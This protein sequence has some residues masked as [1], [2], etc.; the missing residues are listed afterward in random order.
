[1]VTNPELSEVRTAKF[2][3]LH[4]LPSPS[5][6]ESVVVEDEREEEAD[7]NAVLQ[8]LGGAFAM[9]MFAINDD[10][11]DDD[12]GGGGGGGND[13]GDG[14]AAAARLLHAVST[15]GPAA[16]ALAE[17]E[18]WQRLGAEAAELTASGAPLPVGAQLPRRISG[19]EGAAP[20]RARI[21]GELGDAGYVVLPPLGQ[22]QHGPSSGDGAATAAA[23]A[24]S[25]AATTTKAA[26]RT[27]EMAAAVRVVERHGWPPVFALMLDA[28]WTAIQRAW[29]VAGAV[30]G[31]DCDLEPSIFI[32]SLRRNVDP[33]SSQQKGTGAG[34][35]AA[36]VP[37]TAE[38]GDATTTTT[39]TT[40]TDWSSAYGVDTSDAAE[41]KRCQRVG[42]NFGLPHR[43]FSYDE[44]HFPG[45]EGLPRVCNVWIP[46]TDATVDNGCLWVIPKE[47][48][49]MYA[50]PDHYDHS[51]PATPAFEKGVTKL[52]FPVAAARPLP[53]AAGSA[54]AW[55]N[56]IHWGGACGK[57]APVPRIAIAAT[58]K[59]RGSRATHL[60]ADG[61]LGGLL[62]ALR[63]DAGGG[64]GGGGEGAAA[65]AAAAAAASTDPPLL[66]LQSRARLI[67]KALLIY[68]DWYDL[69]KT[70]R[71]TAMPSAF[72]ELCG[73]C[74]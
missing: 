38:S 12:D 16:A 46:L 52:R 19:A 17:S 14:D 1:M 55:H 8:S 15:G 67:A 25:S 69:E 42:Q 48:D 34:A 58:F 39:T 2:S 64:G 50:Q 51:R 31:H 24:G 3:V 61:Q 4:V 10:D 22:P 74:L 45:P 18:Y 6:S 65:A 13:R 40:T 66:P 70:T 54:I 72:F 63:S 36:A 32:W 71:G 30:L 23:A 62:E 26:A 20:E 49:P 9:S 68:E 43:D 73:G 7:P 41:E 11:D 44:A 33:R 29:G 59:V 27:D 56:V 57:R 47:F 5:L 60:T 37:A 21:M 35:P 28:P 53:C